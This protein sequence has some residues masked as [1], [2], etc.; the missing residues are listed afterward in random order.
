[1]DTMAIILVA[2][3]NDKE[4]GALREDK[5][6]GALREGEGLLNARTAL[7]F[8]GLPQR[9]RSMSKT[10]IFPNTLHYKPA[11]DIPVQQRGKFYIPQA[12]AKASILVRC[13]LYDSLPA[14][15]SALSWMRGKAGAAWGLA[16]Y[17]QGIKRLLLLHFLLLR[18]VEMVFM[19]PTT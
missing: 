13:H 6:Q 3:S 5:E 7:Q 15:C 4:Q 17:K 8:I 19:E 11:A 18:F 9:S 10:D 12:F 14:V 2:C 16:V 1:M